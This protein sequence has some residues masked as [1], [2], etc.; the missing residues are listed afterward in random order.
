MK[1]SQADLVTET[2]SVGVLTYFLS[3]VSGGQKYCFRCSRWVNTCAGCGS[4]FHT[5]RAH[6]KTC[7]PK[8]RKKLSRSKV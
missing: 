5:E 1:N 2:C 3:R 4:Q 7:S 8:C 6:A